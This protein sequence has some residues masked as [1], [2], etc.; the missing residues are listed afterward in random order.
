MIDNNTTLS[1]AAVKPV[2]HTPA[3]GLVSSLSDGMV[4]QVQAQ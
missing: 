2:N 3:A 4:Q 1:S